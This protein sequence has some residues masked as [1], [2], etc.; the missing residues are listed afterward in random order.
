MAL[1]RVTD[2]IVRMLDNRIEEFRDAPRFSS[3]L[4]LF[5]QQIQDI[6]DALYQLITD[7]DLV[8]GEGAQLDGIGQLVGEDRSGRTD[9]DYR[10]A[11]RARIALNLSEGTIEQVLQLAV[12]LGA[13]TV[14]INEWFPASI[15]MDSGVTVLDGASI[16]NIV[17]RGIPAGVSFFFT[18]FESATPFKFDTAG[19]GFDQGELGEMVAL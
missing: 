13:T 12:A 2:H 16:A 1:S 18:W 19:Q 9:A 14:T 7:R 17:V 11:L 4:S 5:G 10:L 15:E 3:L 8:S 6:E